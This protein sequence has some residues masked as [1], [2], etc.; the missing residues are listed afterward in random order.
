MKEYAAS[1]CGGTTNG[2]SCPSRTRSR[3]LRIPRNLGCGPSDLRE[4][5]IDAENLT[6]AVVV[7]AALTVSATAWAAT[8]VQ[9]IPIDIEV[10]LCNGDTLDLSGTLLATA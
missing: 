1:T 5:V 6:L 10:G 8:T 7:I 2:A 9:K 4:G 3:T